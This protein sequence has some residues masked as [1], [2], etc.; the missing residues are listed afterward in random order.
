MNNSN[1]NETFRLRQYGHSELALAYCPHLAPQSAWRKL[2]SWL[3]KHPGLR[4]YFFTRNNLRGNRSFTP[5]EVEMIVEAL[6]E[7]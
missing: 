2:K 4:E 7:P 5:R 3:Q 1:T 6:G